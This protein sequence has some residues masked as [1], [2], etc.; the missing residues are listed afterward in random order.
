MEAPQPSKVSLPVE[1]P[2]LLQRIR[3]GQVEKV[4]ECFLRGVLP[5]AQLYVG[6]DSTYH[7]NYFATEAMQLE[8]ASKRFK[9]LRL[10]LEHG[11]HPDHSVQFDQQFQKMPLISYVIER[12]GVR[13]NLPQE[14]L[15]LIA[16]G[17]DINQEDFA[18]NRPIDHAWLRYNPNV[19]RALCLSGAQPI[20]QDDERIRDDER[21][22]VDIRIM[23]A[24]IE[25]YKTDY[26]EECMQIQDRI[27]ELR[28]EKLSRRRK[29]DEQCSVDPGIPRSPRKE[30]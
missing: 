5:H 25:Q 19:L 21:I 27:E 30:P 10:L 24:N 3:D 9:I 26:R 20:D 29:V 8:D 15:L 16:H 23:F 1:T 4:R 11:V 2:D 28:E 14:V 7:V 22:S 18:K 17:A 6:Q 13:N 12:F